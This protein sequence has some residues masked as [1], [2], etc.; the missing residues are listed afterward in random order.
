MHGNII[1]KFAIP[2]F[3][4]NSVNLILANVKALRYNEMLTVSL[5]TLTRIFRIILDFY[6]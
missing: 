3:A 4:E 5:Y 1:S 6:H 2:A